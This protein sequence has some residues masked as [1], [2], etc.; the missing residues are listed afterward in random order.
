MLSLDSLSGLRQ[1]YIFG[2]VCWG[3]AVIVNATGIAARAPAHKTHAF[4]SL[5]SSICA[6]LKL[7]EVMV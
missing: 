1:A 3:I 4:C 7:G 6:R 2:T 5:V